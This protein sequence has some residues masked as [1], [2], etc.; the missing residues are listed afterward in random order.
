MS[1]ERIKLKNSLPSTAEWIYF[2]AEGNFV[3]EYYDHS[4]DAHN[5]F[6][7]DIA[8]LVKVGPSDL[9]MLLREL[10]GKDAANPDREEVILHLIEE[11]FAGYF[12]I[13]KWLE[14][15]QIPFSKVVDDWA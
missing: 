8:Y 2:D 10:Q 14:E 15:K 4:E 12:Q 9:A 13:V 7:S 6:G 1:V 3:A 11:R 5:A